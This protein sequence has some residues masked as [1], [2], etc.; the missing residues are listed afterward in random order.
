VLGLE[1]NSSG[2]GEGT[3]G[4]GNAAAASGGQ[5]GDHSFAPP[6]AAGRPL[7][8]HRRQGVDTKSDAVDD[9]LSP[10]VHKIEFPKFDG[11]GDPMA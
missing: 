3:P 6:C 4:D 2:T 10:S 9:H 1:K 5:G 7:S 11:V 8:L